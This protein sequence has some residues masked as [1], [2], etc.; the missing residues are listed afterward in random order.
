MPILLKLRFPK[1][2]L[3]RRTDNLGTASSTRSA[4]KMSFS[5]SL[6]PVALSDKKCLNTRKYNP[7]L[8]H[9][10]NQS[11][12]S[13]FREFRLL[14]WR[15]TLTDKSATGKNCINLNLPNSV[16]HDSVLRGK[17]IVAPDVLILM[18]LKSKDMTS[19]ITLCGQESPSQKSPLYGG[20]L[21]WPVIK[22]QPQGVPVQRAT[23][24]Q[25]V[26]RTNHPETSRRDCNR[27][28]HN[29][30][31]QSRLNEGKTSKDA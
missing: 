13:K 18:D 6:S 5:R 15:T 31:Y 27:P 14:V 22:I 7:W 26:F 23:I 1:K 17:K 11:Q 24:L 2:K 16:N 30:P 4:F 29:P 25:L 19:H 9:V 28:R 8:I 20:Q 12:Y 3:E 10:K 21:L